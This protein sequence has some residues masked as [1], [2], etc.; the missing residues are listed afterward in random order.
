[1]FL[2][3]ENI[4]M[5]EI[6]GPEGSSNQVRKDPTTEELQI[7]MLNISV[8]TQPL[9]PSVI[10]SSPDIEDV[11]T[12]VLP[13]PKATD[14]LQEGVVVDVYMPEKQE[15]SIHTPET[16][17]FFPYQTAPYYG[18][19]EIVNMLEGEDLLLSVENLSQRILTTYQ[20]SKLL[21]RREAHKM[22][23][24]LTYEEGFPDDIDITLST[25]SSVRFTGTT[26]F[27][28]KKKFFLILGSNEDAE[29]PKSSKVVICTS[30][31]LPK[32]YMVF[33]REENNTK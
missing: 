4:I 17:K 23:V 33:N 9:N 28:D 30:R 20:T 24:G 5:G 10:S 3:A 29:I 32:T 16:L 27:F 1:M 12:L 26:F 7:N 18:S 8:N 21:D 31:L 2:Y 11:P 13:M 25:L 15:E 14:P 22:L 19:I 6:P